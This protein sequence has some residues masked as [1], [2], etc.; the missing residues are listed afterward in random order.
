MDRRHLDD[1]RVDLRIGLGP[2]QLGIEIGEH[3]LGNRQAERPR[4]LSGY[5]LRDERARPLPA[6]RNFKTYSRAVIEQ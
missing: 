1:R 3:D 5:E 2:R 4:N 6:P